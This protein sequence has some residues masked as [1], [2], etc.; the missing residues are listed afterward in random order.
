MSDGLFTVSQ[1]DT[2]A[3]RDAMEAYRGNRVERLCDAASWGTD[4]ATCWWRQV[5]V[6]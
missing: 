1:V 6:N 3:R 4:T 5:E 2:F